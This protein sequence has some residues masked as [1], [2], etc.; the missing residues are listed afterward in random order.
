MMSMVAFKTVTRSAIKAVLV[1]SFLAGVD[2]GKDKNLC[3]EK[4]YWEQ[5]S[6]PLNVDG[7]VP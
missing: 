1:S 6:M 5:L 4:G 3:K 7:H 2:S